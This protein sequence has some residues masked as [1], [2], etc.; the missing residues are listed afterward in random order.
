VTR[1]P[2][3]GNPKPRIIRRTRDGAV[4]N[5]MGLPNR[6]VEFAARKLRSTRAFGPV[7]I[8]LADEDPDDVLWNHAL[9]EPLVRGVE[10]N[11]SCPNVSWGRDRDNEDHLRRLLRGLRERRSKPLF[12][13]LPP[14]RT[15]P[16]R[17]AVLA[18]A[19]IAQEEGADGLTC[20]NSMPVDE[21]RLASGS[22]GLSGRPLLEHTVAGVAEIGGAT[23]GALP[24]NACGGVF[25]AADARDCLEAGATTVQIYTGFVY[26]GPRVVRH[27]T[28][29]I[30]TGAGE[31]R[32]DLGQHARSRTA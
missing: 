27:V 30:R 26:E 15:G 4:V 17:E 31:R 21:P 6:G 11:A 29:G 23:G 10:L 3:R 14:F 25:T 2:R 20:F 19:H 22:G 24:I 16:E 1:R 9:L 28:R 12:V 13:K 7:L 5:S 8:S 32:R 18:L